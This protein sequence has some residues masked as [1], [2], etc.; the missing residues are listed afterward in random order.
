MDITSEDST[1]EASQGLIHHVIDDKV[2]RRLDVTGSDPITHTYVS[3]YS[4]EPLYGTQSLQCLAEKC[5]KFGH[6]V[7]LL[8]M[9]GNCQRSNS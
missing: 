7:W 4:P 9:F 3:P 5:R 2:A 1:A 8:E 6:E